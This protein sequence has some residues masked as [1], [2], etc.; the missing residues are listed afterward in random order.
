MNSRITISIYCM[1][2]WW[3][4]YFYNHYPMP[5]I[6]SDAA[7]ERIYLERQKFLYEQFGEFGIGNPNP[8]AS[9]EYLNMIARYSLDFV[10]HLLGVPLT[11]YDGGGFTPTPLS[12]EA[13]QALKPVKFENTAMAEW[14]VRRYEKLKARY[15][16]AV[17]SIALEGPLN[18]A[19]RI[20]GEE[21]FVDMYENEE[22]AHHLLNVITETTMDIYRFQA[23]LFGMESYTI[24]NCLASTMLSPSN[25][26]EFGLPYDQRLAEMSLELTGKVKAVRMHHCDAVIDKFI[27][28]YAAISQLTQVEA[29]TTSDYGLIRTCLPD[30]T[31]S[32]IVNCKAL[33]TKP[34]SELLKEDIEPALRE[35]ITE[36]IDM[37]SFSVETSPERLKDILRGIR[38]LCKQYDV[39]PVYSMIPSYN[40][41]P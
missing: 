11:T 18:L 40:V 2:E 20:R 10:P 16:C 25:Y 31:M 29:R 24:A 4:A 21:F 27:P 7:L 36:S 17:S 35:D 34:I 38:K 3:K 15:G 23:K 37:W 19:Y 26:A 41:K 12:E 6:P 30:T 32:A 8:K 14:I 33:A 28:H 9:G 1:F 13:V 39:E 22:L 5:E